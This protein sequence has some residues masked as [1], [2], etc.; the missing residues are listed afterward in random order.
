MR[1]VAPSDDE[2]AATVD[3]DAASARSRQRA[4]Q[5]STGWTRTR[6]SA[7]AASSPARRLPKEVA[8]RIEKRNLATVRYPAD[9]K[10]LGDWKNGEK[11]AQEG[12]GMQFSDDAAVPVRRRTATRVTS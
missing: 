1:D 5:A 10:L 9:G 7:R 4:R 12:R 3:R 8:E 2:I 11:I 6:R